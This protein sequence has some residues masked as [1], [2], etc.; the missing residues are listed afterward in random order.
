MMITMDTT[1]E[2]ALMRAVELHEFI[3]SH[4][5]GQY[6]NVLRHEL[7]A[8]F[9]S[10]A[11]SHHRAI[12]ILLD[13]GGV[14][15]TAFALW[16]PLVEAAY[17]GLF[18]GYLANETQIL[19]ITGNDCKPYGSFNQL[20]TALNERFGTTRFSEFAG[21]TWKHLNGLTHGGLAQLSRHMNDEGIV[22]ENFGSDAIVDLIESA[23]WLIA[24][25]ARRFLELVGHD[26][27]ARLVDTRCAEFYPCLGD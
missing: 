18:V 10:V 7:F 27:S 11:K 2:T 17:R 15:A 14:T 26:E 3:D 25:T 20:V 4:I 19:Q 22:A 1:V 13:R 8:R 21:D 5:A 12:L 16:R 24:E 23:T 9:L 6:T